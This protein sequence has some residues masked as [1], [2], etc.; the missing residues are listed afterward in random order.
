MTRD[1]ADFYV[2]T[3]PT[4]RWLGSLAE[5]GGPVELAR[6]G[7]AGDA[8][9]TEVL[10][11]AD[12]GTYEAA[13]AALLTRQRVVETGFVAAPGPDW[14]AGWPWLATT[15]GGWYA[16]AFVDGHV[17]VSTHGG[18]WFRPDLDRP[19]GGAG[20]ASGP[21][22]DL[23]VF[24]DTAPKTATF[25]WTGFRGLPIPIRATLPPVPPAYLAHRG[26]VALAVAGA[27]EYVLGRRW[28]LADLATPAIREILHSLLRPGPARGLHV[29]PA[30]APFAHE[31]VVTALRFVLDADRYAEGNNPDH[32]RELLESAADV[33]AQAVT[34]HRTHQP[35]PWPPR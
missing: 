1:H 9:P 11:A 22:A 10:S 15:S 19:D 3:G 18:P 24:G 6:L 34:A 27:A 14:E 2:G 31:R 4:A 33:A 25:T 7:A 28:P 26:E 16:Y 30:D 35:H 20:V 23:P 17:R 13:V 5:A 12:L 32:A 29:L 21:D 8:E